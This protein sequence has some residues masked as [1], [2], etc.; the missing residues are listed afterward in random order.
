[1]LPR[2]NIS[3]LVLI[4]ALSAKADAYG[5]RKKVERVDVR[6]G[7][8]AASVEDFDASDVDDIFDVEVFDA[9]DF[10]PAN[11][12]SVEDFDKKESEK[13]GNENFWSPRTLTAT[14]E[15]TM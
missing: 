14:K 13:V 6:G 7:R 10:D 1:M 3:C 15:S 9:S 8:E 12:P 5:R 4:V 2:Q 11:R